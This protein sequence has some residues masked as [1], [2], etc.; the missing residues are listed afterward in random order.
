MELANCNAAITSLRKVA[1]KMTDA[2]ITVAKKLEHEWK[3]R[4]HFLR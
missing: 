1:A 3:P 4:L 2:Q